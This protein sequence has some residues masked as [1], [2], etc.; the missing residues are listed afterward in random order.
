VTISNWPSSEIFKGKDLAIRGYFLLSV[1]FKDFLSGLRLFL[2]LF[3][4]VFF[5]AG[6]IAEIAVITVIPIYPF[7]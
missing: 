7:H 4:E 5:E 6:F 3:F 2:R 1:I